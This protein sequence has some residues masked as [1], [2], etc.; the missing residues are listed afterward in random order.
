MPAKQYLV[1]LGPQER[2]QLHAMLKAGRAPA[3]QLAHAHILLKADAGWTDEAIHE[4]LDL[5]VKTCERVRQRFARQGLAAALT[6]KEQLNRRKPKLDGE[7]EAKLLMLAC[8]KPPQGRER[9]T[10]QLLADRL[11]ELKCADSLSYEAVR[12]HLKKKST[13]A[14]A[15]KDVVSGRRAQRRLRL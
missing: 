4:A 2:G 11:V 3:R 5:S 13:G 9:W 1:R 6:R 10:L 14:L 12:Q 7:G 15:Q 8:S